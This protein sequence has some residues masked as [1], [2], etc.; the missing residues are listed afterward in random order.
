MLTTSQIRAA[1]ALL[2]LSIEEAAAVS[3]LSA[4]TIHDAEAANGHVQTEFSERLRTLFESRGV[5]FL[6]EGEAGGGVGVR[7]RQSSQD[8]GMRPQNLNSAND[9]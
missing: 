6:S 7:L 4:E 8:E 2:G 9:G 3:G 5:I 1:R